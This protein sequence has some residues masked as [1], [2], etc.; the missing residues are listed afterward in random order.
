MR[1][2][3]FD[4]IAAKEVG[5]IGNSNQTDDTNKYDANDKNCLPPRF[6]FMI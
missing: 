4:L 3:K 5:K 2:A 6:A 1:L